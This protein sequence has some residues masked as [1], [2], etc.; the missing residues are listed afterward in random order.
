MEE[1]WHKKG[2][3]SPQSLLH[4]LSTTGRCHF[5]KMLGLMSKSFNPE[6]T[7][8]PNELF[9][10]TRIPQVTCILQHTG[11]FSFPKI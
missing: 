9:I 10:K 7:Q 6:Y 1:N 2:G 8:Q 4:P 5:S 11:V 3:C